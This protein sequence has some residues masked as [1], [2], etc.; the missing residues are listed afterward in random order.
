MIV[1]IFTIVSMMFTCYD[2]CK[3]T[4]H[5][6]VYTTHVWLYTFT[7]TNDVFTCSHICLKYTSLYD[8][9]MAMTGPDGHQTMGAWR[10]YPKYPLTSHMCHPW[11]D[12]MV[13][14]MFILE[15]RSIRQPVGVSWKS[16][17]TL[18]H[19]NPEHVSLCSC[20]LYAEHTKDP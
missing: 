12:D 6:H 20:G 18:L 9:S 14:T 4:I 17:A 7:Y 13:Q 2:K 1:S 19:H 10:G 15:R 11:D 16:G 5:T 8:T 3:F